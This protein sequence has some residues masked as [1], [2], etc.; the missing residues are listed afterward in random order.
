MLIYNHKKEFVGIDETDLH[1]LGFENLE[2]LLAESSDFA[3]MFVKTPGYVHNFQHVSW[4]DFVDCA[5]STENTKVIIRAKSKDFRCLLEIKTAYLMENKSSKGFLVTLSNLR[6]LMA[7]EDYDMP[8]HFPQRPASTPTPAFEAPKEK[9][10]EEAPVAPTPPT[11]SIQDLEEIFETPISL[12]AP[13]ELD[14]PVELDLDDKE[15]SLEEALAIDLEID[16]S[17]HEPKALVEEELQEETTTVMEVFDNGYIFDPHVASDELGLPVDLI[18]EFI[19]DFIAQAKEFKNELYQALDDGD[20]DTI[21]TLSHKLKGV[22]ANLRIDDALEILTTINTSDNLIEIKTNLETFY[23]IISKLAG[24][25]IPVNKTIAANDLHEELEELTSE[26]DVHHTIE[27]Q[28][29]DLDM[30]LAP[31]NDEDDEIDIDMTDVSDD[32]DLDIFAPQETFPEEDKKEIEIDMTDVVD[33]EDLDIFAPQETFPEEDEKEIEIDMTDVVDDED[34]DILAP[35]E[36]SIQKDTSTH[37]TT[38]RLSYDPDAVAQEIG[39]SHEYFMEL[40]HD[41]IDEA[42]KLSQTISKAIE[43]NNFA[44]W[45]TK[46][47]QLKGMSDNMRILDFTSELE[48]LIKTQDTSIAKDASVKVTN[49][50]AAISKIEE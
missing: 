40:L 36:V 18:E 45:N 27:D 15:D 1:A 33:D 5:D 29:D 48:I 20:V 32:E 41:Y 46:A 23:K 37:E 4:I 12:D 50:I 2:E 42:Q 24:E 47:M 9:V 49:A 22:A 25:K 10:F 14:A 3:D 28:D 21:Q 6:E 17:L 34:L 31:K 43:E 35:Q 19:E 44:L 26:I 8:S 16:D 7:G 30:L 13:I 38:E 11:H 39:L